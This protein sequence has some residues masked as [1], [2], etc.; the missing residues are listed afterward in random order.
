MFGKRWFWES[1][2]GRFAGCQEWA[3]SGW[4][5]TGFGKL[6]QFLA[7]FTDSDELRSWPNSNQTSRYSV[8]TILITTHS[9]PKHRQTT[10]NYLTP[11]LRVKKPLKSASSSRTPV[12]RLTFII[13]NQTRAIYTR[14]LKT[15]TINYTYS[16]HQRTQQQ[17]GKSKHKNNK[18]QNST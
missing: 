14:K 17:S 10:T 18:T 5:L 7:G 12:K 16:Y 9:W 6:T 4:T 1:K 15:H 13:L 2:G 3:R 8:Q 11:L